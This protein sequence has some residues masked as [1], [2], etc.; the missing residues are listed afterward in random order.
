MIRKGTISLLWSCAACALLFVG[1]S[2]ALAHNGSWTGDLAI[3][4]LMQVTH[5]DLD[6]FKGW[7][8][9]TATNTGNQPWGDFHFG[10]FDPIGGQD[11]SN[12]DFLVDPPYQPTSTQ[13]PLTWAV[14]NVVVGATIDLYYYGDPVNPGDTATFSV[15]TN[16]PDHLAFFG[17]LFYPT[18]VPEPASLALLGLAA[19]MLRR[20]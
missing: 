19:L 13:S 4:D 14:N 16:N 2:A 7:F 9:V 20:R 5:N 12:V 6:P 1:T 17:V 10:I 18:P 11:I 3:G 8:S 15:Y